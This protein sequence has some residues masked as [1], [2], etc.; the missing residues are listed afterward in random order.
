MGALFDGSLGTVGSILLVGA[1]AVALGFEFVNGFHDTANAVAT[2]IYTK[3]LRPTWAVL[4]SGA[5]NFTGVFVGGIAVAMS[6]IRLLPPDML[7]RS[8]NLGLAMVGALLLAAIIWNLGTWYLGLPAS[9]SHTLIGAILGVGIANSWAEGHFGTGVNWTKA[10]EVGLSLLVS[11]MFGF[12]VAALALVTMRKFIKDE[13]IFEP[14]HGDSPPPPW[15]RAFLVLT[16]SGV[17]FAH[18]SNDGQ[19]G[20]GLIMLIL[21]GIVPASYALNLE[22]TPKDLERTY[23]AAIAVEKL[24]A[25]HGD[26]PAEDPKE[27]ADPVCAARHH[28]QAIEASLGGQT[29]VANLSGEDRW[30]VRQHLILVDRAL[31]KLLGDLGPEKAAQLG[32]LRKDLGA[33]TD[34]APLWVIVAVALSLGIGTT[35]GWKRIVVTVGEKIG[36]TH[37]T[38]AQGASAELVA[39]GT[40]GVSSFL[41]LPVSTTH[42]LS[43][44]IAGTMVVDRSGLQV[45][46]VRNIALAWVLTLPA[47]MTL[48][49][50]LFLLF[51]A[52]APG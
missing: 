5:C 33:L 11:P 46:T 6:I 37:L 40:I 24:L 49:G 15:I 22:A 38:Y 41:G 27:G 36:R 23:Q 43:S 13:R 32:P 34:Y 16:C 39:M 30:H 44:G 14:P 1:L 45:G 52:L 51:R 8:G 7:V 17:S 3:T 50:G 28:L 47:S 4:L 21:V 19:K 29:A 35:V 9:S 48:S 12:G 31:P 42:V 26:C 20:V 25:P 18:G 2:V 10:G